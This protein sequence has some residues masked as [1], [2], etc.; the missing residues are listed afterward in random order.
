M[1][2]D[3]FVERIDRRSD[4]LYRIAR[5]ILRSDAD[6][7]DALQDAVLNAW[8]HRARL[9]DEAAFEPWITR[10]LINSCHSIHRRHRRYVPVA[11]VEP[12]PV[13]PPDP[14]LRMA[15][16]ALP[17]NVRLPMMLHYLEGMS[18]GDMAHAGEHG[19]RQA[20]RWPQ[21]TSALA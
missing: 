9:R 17:E 10:I 19:A 15:L 4:M 18:Y 8:E 11:E 2:R 6:C 16:E 1:D 7:Q 20:K 13:Q 3:E 21:G 14:E 12:P 5:T